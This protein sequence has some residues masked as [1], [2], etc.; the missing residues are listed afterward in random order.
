MGEIFCTI[1]HAVLGQFVKYTAL[2]YACGG[3][4]I[5]SRNDVRNEHREVVGY[6]PLTRNLHV[7]IND[8]WNVPR[9]RSKLFWTVQIAINQDDLEKRNSQV[10]LMAEM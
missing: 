8:L 4:S 2:A 7:A 5:P 1:H 6:I 10:A 9:L 3:S